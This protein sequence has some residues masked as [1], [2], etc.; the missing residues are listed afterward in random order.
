MLSSILRAAGALY[1]DLEVAV[2]TAYDYVIEEC[3]DA[4]KA[5][6]EGY[7]SGL[8]TAEDEPIEADAVTPAT[9]TKP[10]TKIPP[11]QS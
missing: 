4:P 10:F 11:Q 3:E 5:L 9:V 1:K 7:E 8:I 6:A 2:N